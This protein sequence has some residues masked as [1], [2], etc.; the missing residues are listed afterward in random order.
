MPKK[1]SKGRA[2]ISKKISHLAKKEGKTQEQAVGQALGM[3][4]SGS[5]GKAAKRAAPPAKRKKRGR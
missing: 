4:R 3:A 5:L 1:P 2:A